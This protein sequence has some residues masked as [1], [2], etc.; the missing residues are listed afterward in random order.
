[1]PQMVNCGVFF[2]LVILMKIKRVMSL[3]DGGRNSIDIPI[4]N[5][6]MTSFMAT[7]Y[8]IDLHLLHAKTTSFNGQSYYPSIGMILLPL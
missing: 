1:M 3:V 4:V 2:K 5:N 8:A 7:G 6:L